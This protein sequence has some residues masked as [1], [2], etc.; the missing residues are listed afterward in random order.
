M[1]QT[2]LTNGTFQIP[3]STV[4]ELATNA[5]GLPNENYSETDR[6]ND[7]RLFDSKLLEL[8]GWTKKSDGLWR[9]LKTCPSANMPAGDHETDQQ[10]VAE[11]R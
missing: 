6:D 8:D 10:S 4:T 7:R 2:G 11:L 3:G 9:G 1:A 5:G